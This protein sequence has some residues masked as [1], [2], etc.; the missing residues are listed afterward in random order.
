[1]ITR[2]AA[3]D[4]LAVLIAKGEQIVNSYHIGEYGGTETRL[5][6][7]DLRAFITAA[8]GAVERI[9]GRSS[10]YYAQ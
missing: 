9:A 7:H 6:E 4:Q 3:L 1:M 8:F 10:E 5:Q 2:Q